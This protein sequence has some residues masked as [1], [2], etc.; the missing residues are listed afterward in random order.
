MATLLSLL[1]SFTI[2]PWLSSRF[3][4]LEKISDN[5]IFG[6]IILSFE[7]G[8]DRFTNWITRILV[9]SL[10]NKKIAL[11]LV[12]LLFVGSFGLVAGGYIGAEFF[13]KSDRGEFLV[14]IEMPK[15]VSIQQTNA[16]TR[17]AESILKKRPEVTKL[18][19][20]VG[21]SSDG[22]ASQ[23]TAYK[24]EIS[25]QLVPRS[26]RVDEASIYAVKVKREL[27]RAL[28]GAKIKTVPVSML[29]TAESAPL[30]LIVTGADLDSVMQFAQ[31]ALAELK[32]IPGATEMR[33]SVEAGNPEINVQVD[34][35]KMAALGLSLATVGGTMQTAFNG[36]TDGKFRQGEYEYDINI[37]FDE[38]NRQ[39]IQDVSNL[40]LVNERG[41]QVRLSQFATIREAS[42]PSELERRDKSTSVTVQS[43]AN[44]WQARFEKLPMPQGVSYLWGGDMENQSEGFGS[45]GIALL[46]AIT[47]V[48]LIM[49]ALYNS[50]IYPFVVLFSIPLAVIGAFLALA[51][52]NNS[53]NLFTI[54][55][56]IMLIGLVAKNAII[57]VDFTNQRKAE[58]QTTYQAL[59]DANHARLRPILMTTI[60]MVIGM[61]PIALAKGAGAEWKNGLAWVIIGGLVSSLFLT[62]VIVPVMYT[63]FDKLVTRLDR[64]KGDKSIQQQMREAYQPSEHH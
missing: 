27:Q 13:A 51:L 23:S 29:G 35:D 15:D 46:A 55:G 49:V 41:E 7:K 24:A 3:G 53:L 20:T 50:F 28:V 19:T 52:T 33:L 37:R 42:G 26:E 36:N 18:I 30:A 32:K 56:M 12:G 39:S 47:L 54:L 45:M 1:S 34:R 16:M 38:F 11:G 6:R 61:L 58:G 48:Y 31:S 9:W 43:Q 8:L 21:Q 40:N 22:S 2:V 25:V 4:K 17:T 10:G 5:N 44:E 59:I 63:L 60:A 14:Q 57:L 64:N 62:L